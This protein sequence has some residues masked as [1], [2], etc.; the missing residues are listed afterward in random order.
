MCERP[1]PSN[2]P[3]VGSHTDAQDA[4]EQSYQP[5]VPLI[6]SIT[7]QVTQ[8]HVQK[9]PANQ[10]ATSLNNQQRHLCTGK[11]KQIEI[12]RYYQQ[13]FMSASVLL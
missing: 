3:D 6:I 2:E 5:A 9:Q 1:W 12:L 10:A 11:T 7:V 4:M 13:I 8:Q